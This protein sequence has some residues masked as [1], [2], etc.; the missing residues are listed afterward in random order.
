MYKKR[1]LAN[2]YLHRWK[3]FILSELFLNT[4]ETLVDSDPETFWDVSLQH[5]KTPESSGLSSRKCI[6][7]HRSR[8][9]SQAVL[10]F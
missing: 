3:A 7:M 10:G 2:K 4:L 9:N 5:L 6:E 1:T 8:Q